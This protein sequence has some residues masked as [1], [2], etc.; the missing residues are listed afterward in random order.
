MTARVAGT[1]HAM[2]VRAMHP[3]CIC[4]TG[5][6]CERDGTVAVTFS[7]EH[8]RMRHAP[9]VLQKQQTDRTRTRRTEGV[10]ERARPASEAHHKLLSLTS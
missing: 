9:L 7:T 10:N 6:V 3:P 5:T 1:A 2:R 8:M 4:H